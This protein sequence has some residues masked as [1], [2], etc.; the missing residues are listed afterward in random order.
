MSLPGWNVLSQVEQLGNV[1]SDALPRIPRFKCCCVNA[2]RAQNTCI[3]AAAKAGTLHWFH[4]AGR[5]SVQP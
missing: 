3:Q 1:A 2:V 4:R 5:D